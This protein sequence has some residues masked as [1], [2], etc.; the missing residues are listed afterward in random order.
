MKSGIGVGSKIHPMGPIFLTLQPD[1]SIELNGTWSQ[2]DLNG[3]VEIEDHTQVP[4]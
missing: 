2:I 4:P 1:E 3:S